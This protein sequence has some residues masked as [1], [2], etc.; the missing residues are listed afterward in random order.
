MPEVVSRQGNEEEK[1]EASLSG[2]KHRTSHG[3]PSVDGFWLRVPTRFEISSHVHSVEILRESESSGHTKLS[4]KAVV[5][6]L[7]L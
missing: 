6:L 4:P 2:S 3:K 5:K 7:L 1:P